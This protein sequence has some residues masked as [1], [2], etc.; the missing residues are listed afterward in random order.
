MTCSVCQSNFA[1]PLKN[2]FARNR[3]GCDAQDE[4]GLGTIFTYPS[5]KLMDQ[6]F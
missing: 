3:C 2:V 1:L 6:N 5:I 4:Q